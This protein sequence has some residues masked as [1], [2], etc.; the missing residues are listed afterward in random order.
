MQAVIMAAGRGKRLNELTEDL[1]KVMMPVNGTNILE[2]I[3]KQL[4]E[5]G[6]TDVVIIVNYKKE[7]IIDYIGNEKFGM[8]LTF[9]E[10]KERLGT[11]NAV[12][13]AEPFITDDHFFVVAG[14]SIFPTE[15]LKKISSHDCDGVLTVCKVENPQ[16]FGVIETEDNKVKNIIEKSETPPTNLANTSIYYFPKEIFSACKRIPLSKRGEY[17]ITDAIQLL[18][19][20][21]KIFEYEILNCWLDV[22]TKSQLEQAQKLAKELFG[23]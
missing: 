21:G 23:H 8:K 14:D 10:Q 9:V 4:S 1:P 3:L 15:V 22:G 2:I 11:A 13:Y 16:S 6:V 17:E 20:E 12:S 7:K 5:T 18:I 19:D